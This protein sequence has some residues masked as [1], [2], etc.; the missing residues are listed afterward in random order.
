L[1]NTFLIAAVS[2]NFIEIAVRHTL[3]QKHGH[4]KPGHEERE[5]YTK[6]M[7]KSQ[8]EAF[9]SVSQPIFFYRWNNHQPVPYRMQPVPSQKCRKSVANTKGKF[10][11]KHSYFY[12][13]KEQS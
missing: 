10:Y 7:K 1:V 9:N 8:N 6:I 5:G 2:S 3:S 11:M 4:E 13:K 12:L